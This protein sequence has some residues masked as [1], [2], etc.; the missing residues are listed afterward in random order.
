LKNKNS[1]NVL[2]NTLDIYNSGVYLKQPKIIH[3][4]DGTEF[5]GVFQE[6]FE[7]HGSYI[8]VAQPGRHRQQGIVE[9]KNRLISQAIMNRQ[10]SREMITEEKDT[11]W[12]DFIPIL[13]KRHNKKRT[14]SPVKREDLI[15]PLIPTSKDLKYPK[16]ISKIEKEIKK[17]SDLTKMIN[18]PVQLKKDKKIKLLNNNTDVRI[19]LSHPID[20]LN[21]KRKH[22]HF[23]NGDTRWTTETYKA[24]PLILPYQ[25]PL[26]AIDGKKNVLYTRKELQVAD[27]KN[28]NIP[29]GELIFSEKEQ[30]D[31]NRKWIIEKIL[32]KQ[33][34]NGNKVLLIKWK[35]FE[36]PSLHSYDEIKKDNPVMVKNFEDKYI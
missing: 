32:D 21:G 5:K 16:D 19:K 34:I 12:V 1:E 33:K 24:N 23:R 18:H 20:Y 29:K 4:D 35:G 8:R 27:V 2:K 31:I 7:N 9:N 6:Y 10:L 13:I 36:K 28:E 14:H 30:N 15:D 26:Y 3:V 22:G 11:S 25:P 17:D